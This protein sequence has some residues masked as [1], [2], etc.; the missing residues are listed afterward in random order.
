MKWLLLRGLSR[1]Q[2]HW[3]AFLPKFKAVFGEENVFCLDHVGVGTES[4]RPPVYSIDAM[5]ADLRGRWKQLKQSEDEKWAILSL[6][7]GSMVSLH[8]CAKYP[9]DFKYQV[10]INVSSSTDSVPWNRLLLDNARSFAQLARSPD[11]VVR[12]RTVLDMC[13]NLLSSAEKS[14]LAEEWSMF[15]LDRAQMRKVALTQ[16]WAAST[17]RRPK[18]MTVPTL[19]MVSAADRLVHP[20]CTMSIATALKLH[21]EVNPD[22]GHEMTIDAS[23]WVIDQVKSF[24]AKS[25]L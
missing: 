4:S 18:V 11:N 20:T 22:A 9:E 10:V 19:A 13:T 12:E 6:S 7:M 2:R 8:W 21:L 15:S 1:E 17:F 5:A 14:K 3:G 16:L 25:V 23:D 24:T